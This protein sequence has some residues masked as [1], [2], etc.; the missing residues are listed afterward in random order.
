MPGK[1][2]NLKNQLQSAKDPQERVN[3]LNNLT[4]ELRYSNTKA[5]LEY[6]KQA[7][8]LSKQISYQKGIAYS[9]LHTAICNFLLSKN[10]KIL[11]I[12]L[13]SVKYFESVNEEKGHVIALNFTGNVYE[14]YGDYEKGLEYCQ[15]ALKIARNIGYKEGEGDTLSTIGLIY[16]R[17]SDYKDALEFY[18]K[19]L[20]IREELKNFKAVAS[21]LNLI[22]RTNSLLGN[23]SVAL[24]YYNKSLK[25]RKD[26]KQFGALAWTYIGIAST[27]ENMKDQKTA[28]NNYFEGIELNKE[29]GD[30]RCNLHCFLGIGRIYTKLKDINKSLD[31]LQKA[32]K[33]AQIL[34]TKPLL[35]ETHFALAEYYEMTGDL[36]KA[37]ENYK[38]Y[39]KIKEEVLNAETHNRLMNQQFRFTI[40]KAEKE[41]EIYQL[42]NVELKAVLNEIEKKNKEITDSIYY[43]ERIQSAILPPEEFISKNLPE[44]FILF[45]PKDI[46]S[47]D[48]YWMT[49]KGNKIVIAVADSTGHGV[50]GAFMSLL[51]V[52]FLNEIVNKVVVIRANEILNQLRGQII[53][54]LHQTGKEDEAK[55]GI[56]IALCIINLEKKKL[57]YSGA[58]SPLYLV[59][60]NELIEIKADKM[61]IGIYEDEEKS[62]T[63]KEIQLEKNDI[64]YL[65][66]DGYVDQLGGPKRKTFRSKYF[67]QLL[68]DIHDK[69][70]KKQKEIL[71][72]N[73]EDW[74][75]NI[76]QIDD[77]LVMGIKIT[78]IQ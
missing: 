74:K 42:R 3:I 20:K 30:K 17:L 11:E 73:M 36:A 60:Y 47:G 51:G 77:V 75:G 13:D 25:I 28:L 33:N 59:R 38:E 6:N 31:Y 8:D 21:S 66:S 39:Q 18:E 43:A 16:S 55:D 57:Q 37:L 9:Q 14:S 19:S 53:N 49:Q 10:D 26:L 58:F 65:F 48:F 56:E 62:F 44:H 54:S 76:E 5:A 34:K 12:L 72:K 22:A 35:Y 15:M 29:T 78:N 32:L 45:K 41:K 70:M 7:Y 27:Y 52:A 68:I 71:E 50:P 67:K 40:E 23:Y 63:S 2:Q 4:W 24:E 69:P 61:P 1:I 46:V 64:I